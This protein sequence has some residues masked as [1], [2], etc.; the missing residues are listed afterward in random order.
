MK[1]YHGSK[2]LVD[3]L[4]KHQALSEVPVPE[5][6]LQNAVYFT[7]EYKMAVAMGGRPEGQTTILDDTIAYE[8]QELFD[9][10]E[11]IYVYEIDSEKFTDEVLRKVDENQYVYSGKDLVPE[12]VETGKAGDVFKYYRQIEWKNRERGENEQPSERE[13]LTR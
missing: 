4:E 13:R 10:E 1:L 8:H 3:T 2:I 6:E 11:K 9:P 12:K 5:G 7:P